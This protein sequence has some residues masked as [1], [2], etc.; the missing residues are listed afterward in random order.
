MGFCVGGQLRAKFW[1][2]F[3]D[4]FINAAYLGT[5]FML[6][7]GGAWHLRKFENGWF[8]KFSPKYFFFAKLIFFFAY[9]LFFICFYSANGIL[10]HDCFNFNGGTVCD[11]YTMERGVFLKKL[12]FSISPGNPT[13]ISGN[14]D[15]PGVF[16]PY[17]SI[18]LGVQNWC[19]I[20]TS[21]EIPTLKIPGNPT[22]IFYQRIQ[23]VRFSRNPIMNHNN[24][25]T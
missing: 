19:E 10:N 5:N 20:L 7:E 6:G 13:L 24:S 18:I 1:Q 8:S 21:Q 9:F 16:I 25:Q 17:K 22:K 3:F 11:A 23:N 14:S 15:S 4:S 2:I 12:K